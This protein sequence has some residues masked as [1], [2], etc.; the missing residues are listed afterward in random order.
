MYPILDR[1]GMLSLRLA[2]IAASALVHGMTIVMRN[3]ADFEPMGVTII[4]PWNNGH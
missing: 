2:F 1:R 4:S 3:V